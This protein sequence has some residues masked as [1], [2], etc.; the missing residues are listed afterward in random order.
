MVVSDQSGGLQIVFL[1]SDGTYNVKVDG[2]LWPSLKDA[3]NMAAC[4]ASGPNSKHDFTLA[5]RE[6][7]EIPA[8]GWIEPLD[9]EE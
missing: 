1:K 9:L 4:Y 6:V 3:Q 5:D 2:V 7:K 8:A